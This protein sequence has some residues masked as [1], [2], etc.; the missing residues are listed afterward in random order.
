MSEDGPE[1]IHGLQWSPTRSKLVSALLGVQRVGIVVRTDAVDPSQRDS[2]GNPVAYATLNALL[3]E[4][5]HVL[6]QHQLVLV[7]GTS[8]IGPHLA[9]ITAELC[10]AE[11]EEWVRTSCLV[12]LS[13]KEPK[14]GRTYR[15]S[16]AKSLGAAITSGRRYLLSALLNISV[17]SGT[18][19]EDADGDGADRP[20]ANQGRER[21]DTKPS[22]GP[23]DIARLAADIER[24]DRGLL[25]LVDEVLREKGIARD[26]L[27]DDCG[28][29]FAAIWRRVK[30]PYEAAKARRNGR[31]GN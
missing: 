25:R 5:C 17:V 12:Q 26:R 28:A 18:D 13:T 16:S 19:H 29:L 10:L 11:T 6:S 4:A 27:P 30:E 8:W 2:E 14:E 7:F 9:V 24:V 20:P 22:R 15:E 3:D 23:E 21:Q 1:P 31:H